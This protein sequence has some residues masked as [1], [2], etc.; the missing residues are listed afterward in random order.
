MIR[1]QIFSGVFKLLLLPGLIIGSAGYY[2]YYMKSSKPK[3]PAAPAT[4]KSW[5]IAVVPVQLADRS[6]SLTLYGVVEARETA[7]LSTTVNG[8]VK[9]IHYNKGDRVNQGDLLLRMDDQELRLILK[10]RQ[11]SIDDLEA[12][13]ANEQLRFKSDQQALMIEQQLQDIN[14]HNLQRQQSL[15]QQNMSA[16]ARFEDALRTV[17]QQQL[18]IMNRERSIAEHPSRLAQLKAQ[19]T[20]SEVQLSLAQIDLKRSRITAPF[21]GRILSIDTAVGNRVRNGDR[22]LSLYNID[23][24]EIRTQI[25]DRYLPMLQ[26]NNGSELKVQIS[27]QGKMVNLQLQRLAAETATG[28]GGVD[29]YFGLVGEQ[30]MHLDIGRN[31]QVYVQLPPK[32]NVAA[33]PTQSIYGQNRVYRVY[34]DR[35]QAIM[36]ERV[37]QWT[38]ADGNSLTLVSGKQLQEGDLLMTTQLPNAV[39]GLLVEVNE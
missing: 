7:K 14:N 34:D 20:H 27:V 36:I 13:I 11:A 29:A 5:S 25:P 21:S 4:E 19:A 9:A 8:Y 15:L 39:T 3:I 2:F 10:Q 37:G 30:A 16:Q 28:R 31:V 12:R 6:P 33:I 22:L 18:A 32:R 23:S 1:Q 17:R 35:L 38:D 26:S 24:L